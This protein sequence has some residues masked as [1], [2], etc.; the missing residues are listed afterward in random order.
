VVEDTELCVF[1]LP[2][3]HEA[4][5]AER[6]EIA[7]ERMFSGEKTAIEG[8]E[9][10]RQVLGAEFSELQFSFQSS[11]GNRRRP[12]DFRDSDISGSV[13]CTAARLGSTLRLEGSRIGA[14]VVFRDAVIERD[15]RL[16]DA[17]IEG[18]VDAQRA[19]IRGRLGL[20]GINC[21]GRCILLQAR[22]RHGVHLRRAKLGG[23]VW[24]GLKT[25]GGIQCNKATFEGPLN[26]ERASIG[27]DLSFNNSVLRNSLRLASAEVEGATSL[28]DTRVLGVATFTE[29]KFNSDF[30]LRTT[31]F[32]GKVDMR[33]AEIADA[34]FSRAGFSDTFRANRATFASLTLDATH[35]QGTAILSNVTITADASLDK[36]RVTDG[37]HLDGATIEGEIQIG[38]IDATNGST[39]VDCTEGELRTGSIDSRQSDDIVFDFTRATLGDIRLRPEQSSSADGSETDH[40]KEPFEAYRF[41]RTTFDGFDFTDYD[42][43]L[44]AVDWRLHPEKGDTV[45]R[46]GITHPTA[47]DHEKTYTKAKQGASEEGATRAAGAFLMQELRY[48]RKGHAAQ[49]TNASP[50]SREWAQGWYRWLANWVLRLT[51]GYGERLL[52][53]LGT[54]I[55]TMV[56]FAFI[57]YLLLPT[58]PYDVG[59]AGYG[60][61]SLVAFVTLVLGEVSAIEEFWVQVLAQV[62]GLLGAFLI[63]LFVFVF[64]RAVHR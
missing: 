23:G 25:E 16:G 46:N 59:L 36:T 63:A 48:R 24:H 9:S 53:V 34:S 31:N 26:A 8:E 5:T 12:I 33:E 45:G 18:E 44:E 56:L 19:E 17:E 1:H 42:T 51:A 15:V 20:D 47:A 21:E 54:T 52:P 60:L 30:D 43:A 39:V 50:L 3:A 11:N 49:G 55:F 58:P 10:S 35:F 28:N 41:L 22:I 27:G 40:D 64:T 4:K 37:L 14:D 61:L 38:G 57:Y 29:A 6:V 7:L 62:E 32:R 13:D 2:Q